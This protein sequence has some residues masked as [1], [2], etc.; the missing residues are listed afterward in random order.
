MTPETR[1]RIFRYG[2]AI[3]LVILASAVGLLV[4]VG[5]TL[6]L[7]LYVAAAALSAWKG[8]WS[9]AV[10]ATGLSLAAALYFFPE[11]FG[12]PRLIGLVV[13]SLA[14]A[15]LVR[16]LRSRGT[17]AAV[18]RPAATTG[19]DTPMPVALVTEPAA[20][21]DAMARPLERAAVTQLDDFREQARRRAEE[22]QPGGRQHDKSKRSAKEAKRRAAEEARQAA[23]KEKAAKAAAE[24]ARRAEAARVR[25]EEER[26]RAEEEQKKAEE[27]QRQAEAAR[28]RAEEERRSEQ[29]RVEQAENE[30]RR[31]EEQRQVIDAQREEEAAR[32]ARA[33]IEALRL[34]AAELVAERVAAARADIERE[35]EER[36]AAELADVRR[37]AIEQAASE[38]EQRAEAE[39]AAIRATVDES[40]AERIVAAR[41]EAERQAE[42]RLAAEMTEAQRL[43]EESQRALAQQSLMDRIEAVRR[44]AEREAAEREQ[45]EIAALR[46]SLDQNVQRRLLAA[47]AELDREVDERVMR[48]LAAVREQGDER[49]Q[50]RL[51][52]ELAE[53]EH[54]I[55]TRVAREL[56]ARRE[57]LDREV[58][59]RVALRAAEE[60]K[61]ADALVQERIDSELTALSETVEERIARELAQAR[62]N[63]DELVQSRLA[64]EKQE[65]EA[66]LSAELDE[67]RA[68]IDR[69]VRE[70]AE[71]ARAELLGSVDGAVARELEA[72]RAQVEAEQ[73]ARTEQ[74]LERIR[75]EAEESLARSIEAERAAHEALIEERLAGERALRAAAIENDLAAARAQLEKETQ[76]RITV[77]REKLRKDAEETIAAARST[78]E[79]QEAKRVKSETT[80]GLVSKVT[81][82]FRPRAVAPAVS[83]STKKVAL[84][85]PPAK[86]AAPAAPLSRRQTKNTDRRPRL[87]LLERRRA[88]A[89]TIVP[90]MRQKG[91]EIEVVE[92]WIDAVDELFRFRPDALLLDTELPDLDKIF[93]TITEQNPRLPVYVTG[94]SAQSFHGSIPHVGFI[95]RPYDIEHLSTVARN[96]MEQPEA[97]TI[98]QNA[99]RQSAAS[100]KPAA[101]RTA[102]PVTVMPRPTPAPKPA[103]VAPARP[104]ATPAAPS[105]ADE[106]YDF[107]SSTPGA[108]GAPPAVV[109]AI[110]AAPKLDRASDAAYQI[111]C[112]NCRVGFDA[113]DADWCSCL[114]K[115]RTLVCTNCLTC[116]CK[117]PPAYKE[118]FWV[119]APPR[120]FERKS[121][122]ARRGEQPL[123]ENPSVA[124]VRRPLVLSVEDDEDIQRIVQ[125]VCNNLGYGFLSALNGQDGLDLAREY[126]PNLILSDAF[127][128]KLDGREMCRL[129]KEDPAF[130]DCRMVIMTGLYT[131][132]KYRS[133]AIKRFHVDDYIAKPVAITDLINLL[134]RHLEGVS[135]F[136]QQEDLHSMHRAEIEEQETRGIEDYEESEQDVALADLIDAPAI[137]EP[138]PKLRVMKSDR[139]EVCCYTCSSLFEATHAEWCSCLGRDQ[140]LL[141]PDCNTCFCKSPSA[142]KERFWMDAPPS[143]FE[144][145]MIGSKRNTGGRSNPLPS[146]VKRPL[147]LL[148]EDDEN[149]QLIVRTVVSSMGFGFIVGANG[150]EGLALAREYS[151]DLILSDAFMPKLDGREMCRLLKEDPITAR[152]K[153]IIMTGLYTDRK[154]RNEALDYFKVDDYVAKPLAVDDLIKLFKKHLPQEVQPTM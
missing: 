25:A 123:L 1:R 141:C 38:A 100:A 26:V 11:A 43:A 129:L 51:D 135:E 99:S 116:F 113:S 89:D 146:E 57:E 139:Y 14:A 29:L 31:A 101:S 122:D 48:E 133:E 10:L 27:E 88:T 83:V 128:P 86:K 42:E 82:W 98:L 80:P 33:E 79:Q 112:F 110:A 108:S 111:G 114:T 87:L 35:A 44:Q 107:L 34:S 142:Y 49:I 30:R 148:V 52:E 91:V 65:L 85:A 19:I 4:P 137:V 140:T 56:A 84:S 94:K 144:R 102:A 8:G 53:F 109:A 64:A 147:I 131:D 145:K 36:I 22:S 39:I 9:G 21:N 92:R 59:E 81:S 60:R 41:A 136:P 24:Q 151:P 32:V 154:Y 12:A 120:L 67:E 77:E 5:P 70:R 104:P 50:S 127:M 90:R 69:E 150:Q 125:R 143:L 40:I 3:D 58:A 15:A 105:P 153:A 106:P 96:A 20:V 62:R 103:A 93:K 124:E 71:Q 118:K 75:R 13:G 18:A 115:E 45:H 23:E 7:T 78:I 28:A 132:T 121:A 130:T 138:L 73:R 117:A 97:L 149:I 152:I 134:Q 74:E 61:R 54:E 63:A 46:A 17:A 66:R 2:I 47:R 72:A 76:E 37:R 55:E 68:R 95:T 6:L 126:H 119:E 16:S